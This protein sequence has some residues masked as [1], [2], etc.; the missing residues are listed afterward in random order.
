MQM[1]IWV[2][3]VNK[4]ELS[5]VERY[6]FEVSAVLAFRVTTMFLY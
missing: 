2:E 1:N 5:V 3:I 6:R 4:R